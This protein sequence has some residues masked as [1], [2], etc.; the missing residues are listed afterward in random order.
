MYN[1]LV[2][3]NETPEYANEVS[4][5]VINAVERAHNSMVMVAEAASSEVGKSQVLLWATA[6]MHQNLTAKLAQ[7]DATLAEEFGA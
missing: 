6:L 2:D 4:D 7:V 1:A 5:L 3:A